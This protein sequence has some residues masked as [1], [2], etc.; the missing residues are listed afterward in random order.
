M[1]KSKALD[2]RKYPFQ[3]TD[4][5]LIDA[6]IWLYVTGPSGP[7]D[8]RAKTYSKA[9]AAML[10]ARSHLY[11]N[12][13]ILSEFINR[14]ARLEYSRYSGS[15]PYSDFKDYRKSTDFKPIAQAIVVAVRSILQF[16]SRIDSGFSTLDIASLL[17]EFEEGD[18]DFNDQVLT[19]LCRRRGLI[20]ATHDSDFRD[21]GL[22]VVTANGH[23]LK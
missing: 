13:L 20:L 6:N 16:C 5:L 15:V 21:Q 8:W 10:A 18:S 11:I 23:L 12:V 17:H 14:Y 4:A 19:D 9:L 2:I 7:S 3:S 22:T 1:T